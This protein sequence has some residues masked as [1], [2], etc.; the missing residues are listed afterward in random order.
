M[1][2]IVTVVVMV[3]IPENRKQTTLLCC[4][5]NCCFLIVWQSR[6]INLLNTIHRLKCYQSILL[7]Q[8]QCSLKMNAKSFKLNHVAK[9]TNK[10]TKKPKSGPLSFF[11]SY[12][13][14]FLQVIN[15][16]QKCLS[17]TLV[18]GTIQ[19]D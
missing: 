8:C 16:I 4:R 17:T 2:I 13:F 6:Y 10:K 14:S 12:F 18:H 3:I 9:Y 19:R 15:Q 11:K 7:F 5:N 1:H